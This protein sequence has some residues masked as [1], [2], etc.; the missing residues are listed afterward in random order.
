MT[1]GRTAFDA[2]SKAVDGVTHDGRFIPQWDDLTDT[3]RD[4]WEAAA[5][6]V[7]A[8]QRFTLA[9]AKLPKMHDEEARAMFFQLHVAKYDYERGECHCDRCGELVAQLVAHFEI[10]AAAADAC[11]RRRHPPLPSRN[12]PVRHAR[13]SPDPRASRQLDEARSVRAAARDR[14]WIS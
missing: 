13:P 4:A 7:L 14:G 5:Q 6:A 10:T 3:V 8:P 9:D 1:A 12:R 2:Y 11:P